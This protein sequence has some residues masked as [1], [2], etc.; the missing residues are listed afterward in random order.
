[1]LSTKNMMSISVAGILI[2]SGHAAA[3]AGNQT[4]DRP[5]S[6]AVQGKGT[7]V[8]LEVFETGVKITLAGLIIEFDFDTSIV[9]YVKAEDS[10]FQLS[11][12]EDSIRTNLAATAPVTLLS[13]GF[14]TRFPLLPIPLVRPVSL[15]QKMEHVNPE[16]F[17]LLTS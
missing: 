6:G 17:G 10:A 4:D 9:A 1:M 12:S 2:L 16:P 5:T 3:G 15:P 13:S 8:A 7:T 14:V 11:V